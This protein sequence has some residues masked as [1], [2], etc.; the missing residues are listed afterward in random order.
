M[1]D[2]EVLATSA[3][4]ASISKTSRL[5]Q[6]INEKDKEPSWDGNI[7]LHEDK[8]KTKK[9]IYKIPVQVKGKGV[10]RWDK[11]EITYPVS[12]TD[13]ENYLHDGG[14]I[15]FVVYIDK[16]TGDAKQIYYSSLLPK[17]I[18]D[19]LKKTPGKQTSITLYRFPDDEAG[20]LNVFLF[21]KSHKQK[22][23]VMLGR[24]DLDIQELAKNGMIDKMSFT[25][26]AVGLT[27]EKIPQFMVEQKEF[28]LYANIKG[29]DL[30]VPYEY[31]KDISYAKMES[32]VKNP[33]SVNGVKYY[34]SY[35][36]I[37]SSKGNLFKIGEST[38]LHFIQITP[39]ETNESLVES[40]MNVTI[41]G[42]LRAR[43]NDLAFVLD[44]IDSQK[45][46]IAGV[47]IPIHISEGEKEKFG[48]EDQKENLVFLKKACQVLD[49]LNVD[50][51]LKIDECSEEDYRNLARLHQ[52]LIE[53]KRVN[54]LNPEL[55][56]VN[57]IKLA[58]LNLII[59]ALKD[60]KQKGCFRLLNFF[61]T[62]VP[63]EYSLKKG[64]E[65]LPTSQYGLLTS[66]DILIADNINYANIVDDF[67]NIKLS[68]GM[69]THANNVLLEMIKA[70]DTCN[71]ED[72]YREM[73]KFAEW[74]S[75]LDEAYIQKSV[76]ELNRLQI[77]KRKRKLEFSEK[78]IL[79]DI[80]QKN[81]EEQYS[82]GAL[83]LLDE[84]EE[85]K[86]RLEALDEQYQEQF[87]KYPICKFLIEEK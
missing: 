51:D 43:T 55:G 67:R 80:I 28:Y 61:D 53:G 6:Y 60:E 4:K 42:T 10:S 77:I 57:K 29:T 44:M 14:T 20:K 30:C 48:Y 56:V 26:S 74:I 45:L 39:G 12:V 5:S 86:R 68:E 52:S 21:F 2:Y 7:Y 36:V 63:V 66:D 15:F 3:V 41:R 32:V 37:Y 33:V 81:E 35:K 87:K 79:L 54:G 16:K 11:Q 24:P 47:E 70:F 78:Q 13:L 25:L 73:L 18:D 8:S 46:D 27:E 85:A 17:K 23:A 22:Q 58:N 75:T 31:Y 34:D 38:E 9:N 1:M 69:V 84:K 65:R 83:L 72:L 49:A 64:G 82:I 40:K 62:T 50:K 19:L 71:N 76:S 59:I